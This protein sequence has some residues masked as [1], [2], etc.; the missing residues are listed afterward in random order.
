MF[1]QLSLAALVSLALPFGGLQA[2]GVAF[3]E[4]WKEQGFLRLWTNDYQFRGA[5]LDVRSEGTVSLVWRPVEGGLRQAR[6]ASWNWRVAQG[7]RPTDLTQ[8][9]G[10]DRNLALYFVFVDQATAAGLTDNNA[11]KLLG[12]PN[13]RALIYVWGGAHAKGEVLASPYHPG[14]RSKILRTGDV[15]TFAE[16]V[17][18]ARDF[19]QAFGVEPGVLVGLAVSADSDDTDGRI[20]ASIANLVLN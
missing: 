6:Q 7:V 3:D 16:T 4:T 17:D 15:G 9:G 10:D 12:N 14:L 1:R 13:T 19:R 18:L 8:K 11:R 5:Q 2:A 20:R